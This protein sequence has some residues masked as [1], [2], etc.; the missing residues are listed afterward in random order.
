M[1]QAPFF[2]FDITQMKEQDVS[3]LKKF[4]KSNFDV[5]AVFS[6]AEDLKYSNQIKQLLKKQL[7]EPSDSF[8]N[9]VLS[10]VYFG[11][12][13]QNIIDKFKPVIKKSLNQFVNDLMN[14]RITAA[15]N[16]SNAVELAVDETTDNE[17]TQEVN[18]VEDAPKFTTTQEELDGFAIVKAILYKTLSIERIFYRDTASYFGILCD[19]KNYKWICRLMVEKNIKYIVIPDGSNSGKKYPIETINN[20]FDYS[21]QIIDSAKRFVNEEA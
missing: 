5:N 11:R 1:D 8:I 19:D 18:A 4:H 9:Y 20:I 17:S 12:K 6:A 7:E 2:A 10:E 3:E 15:L 21:S 16:K 13:T 14:D